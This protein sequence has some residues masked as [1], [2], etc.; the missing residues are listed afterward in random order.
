[1]PRKP[2]GN[3][4][5]SR[6]KRYA[7]IRFR[8]DRPAFLLPTCVTEEAADERAALLAELAA[9]LSAAEH[10][11][12]DVA[13]GLLER[14]A[15]RDGKALAAVREAVEKLCRGEVRPIAAASPRGPT[16]EELG[17]RWTSGELASEYPD[18]VR[19][20][21]SADDDACRLA[22]YVYP[23]VG[24]VPVVGVHIDD[25]DPFVTAASQ[26][27]GRNRGVVQVARPA[28]TTRGRVV[29]RRPA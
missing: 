3:S 2:T 6:G 21:E 19:V 16:I 14:A 22:L 10:V 12:A 13:R 23:V 17:R 9:K 24:P 8:G 25:G 18:H 29:A 1:M 15:Q 20:K 27:F 7:R 26:R 5:E 4:F 11:H 28:E